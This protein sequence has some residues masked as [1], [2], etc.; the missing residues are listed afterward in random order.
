MELWRR[1]PA[2]AV[3]GAIAALVLARILLLVL[4]P[5]ELGADEAQYWRWAQTLDWGY[6]SKPPLIAWL[7]AATTTVFRDSEWAVRLSAPILHGLAGWFLFDLGRRMF[8]ARTG[9]WSAAIYLLMPGVT[10]SSAIM[11]TDA[12]LLPCWSA[13]MLAVWMLRERP[14][15]AHGALLGLALGVGMLAK[16]AAGYLLAGAALAALFDPQTRRALLSLPGLVALLVAAAVLSPN[17]IWNA[18]HGFETVSHTADN[19][20]LGAADFNILRLGEFVIDQMGVFGPFGVIGLFAAAVLLVRDKDSDREPRRLWLAAFTA[21][22]LAVIAVQAV[23][24]GAHANWAATAYPSACVLVASWIGR[25]VWT[26]LSRLNVG[27]NALLAL[28]FFAFTLSP[29]L[30]DA[31]GATGAFKRVRGSAQLV[32]YL[33]AIARDRKASVLMFD[34]REIWHVVD[35]Y[36]R[37]RI[38]PP[39]R[40][41]R[42]GADPHSYAEQAGTMQPGEDSNVLVISE[43]STFLARIQADFDHFEAIGTLSIPIGG[44]KTRVFRLYIGQGYHPLPR[45][46]EYEKSFK[47]AEAESDA[48][49]KAGKTPSP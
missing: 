28:A 14:S 33:D 15:L 37:N 41:W 46:A 42:R 27:F 45:T 30:A 7:I 44:E 34:E 26:W 1:Q 47:D 18:T 17:L 29:A 10:L 16:Y 8:D 31:A 21:P 4:T 49:K 35:Y 38:L 2:L 43:P 22:P 48:K 32:A 13:A 9:A 25:P 5:M 3:G 11:S 36:G 23:I 12:V 39:L 6:Y 20:N 40:A 24:S 19:A